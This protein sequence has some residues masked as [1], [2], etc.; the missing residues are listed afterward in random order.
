MKVGLPEAGDAEGAGQLVGFGSVWP[1][2]MLW[3]AIHLAV[4]AP[5]PPLL[6]QRRPSCDVQLSLEVNEDDHFNV[7]TTLAVEQ[8]TDL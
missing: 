1:S 3:R 6:K 5:A 4:I 7:A 2:A 8:E